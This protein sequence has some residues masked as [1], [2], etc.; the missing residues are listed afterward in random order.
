MSGAVE[1]QAF[2]FGAGNGLSG[3]R[4]QRFEVLNWGTFHREV[5]RIAPGGENSLLTGDIGSG[6][7]TLVD[8]LTTLLVPHQKITYNKAAGAEGRE[9]SL[10][11]YVRGE[12]KS[13]QDEATQGARAVALRDENSYSVLL[14]WFHNAG[15]DQGASLAQVFW[16]KEGQRRPERFFVIAESPLTIRGDFSDFGGDVQ[17]LRKRLRKQK[18]VAVFD[19]FKEYAARFRRL[20][21]IQQEKALE[22]F[23]QAVSMKSVGNLTD[24]V[25]THML[26]GFEVGSRIEELRRNFENLN[27]AHEA[28]LKAKD[29]IERL[30]PL[31]VE[32]GKHERYQQE[33]G[34]LSAC[35]EA[36]EPWFAEQRVGLTRERMARLEGELRTALRRK[37]RLQGEADAL[38]LKADTLKAG[39]EDSGGSRLRAIDQDIL[40]LEPQRR[41]RQAALEKYS[42]YCTSLELDIARDV[43]GFERNRLQADE[44]LTRMADET[45]RLDQQKTRL[46]VMLHGLREQGRDLESELASLNGRESNIPRHMLRIRQRMAETLEEEVLP[47]AG[48]LL[49]M[50]DRE[51]RWAGAAERLLHGFGLSLLVPETHYAEVSRYVDKTDLKGRLVYYRTHRRATPKGGAEPHPDAL[52]RKLMIKPES[53][54]YD[55]LKGWLDS[56]FDHVCCDRLEDFHRQPKAVTRQGQ[57]K[58]GGRRHEKDD[59]YDL[60]DRSRYVLGWSNREKIAALERKLEEVAGGIADQGHEIQRIADAIG[61][62]TR[63][64]ANANYLLNVERFESIDWETPGR[65]ITRLQQEKREIEESSDRLQSLRSQLRIV[66][67]AVQA[68]REKISESIAEYARIEERLSTLGTERKEAERLCAVWDGTERQRLQQLRDESDT[69]TTNLQNLEKQQRQLRLYIQALIDKIEARRKRCNERVIKWMQIYKDR[70]QPETQEVDAAIGSLQEF[71]AM[72]NALEAE[73]L[74]R[75][76]ARFRRLLRDETING[77]QLFQAQLDRE[78]QEIGDKIDA[79]NNSLR[80]IE[81]NAGSYIILL[82]DPALDAEIRDFRQQLRQLLSGA[83]DEEQLYT[84]EKFLQVKAI[85]DRFN[86]REGVSDLDRRWTRK[87]TDVRNWFNFSASERWREDDAEREFYSD[88]AGKSGG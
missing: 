53:P 32:G 44:L 19:T 4:L 49:Q 51:Q 41:E 60:Y 38:E 73:D 3:F 15:F 16:H 56:R 7:S 36:L 75:H 28:V 42:G 70:Y 33:I 26:E 83:L 13:E 62:L 8:A 34:T 6:K 24:F 85:I 14:A 67:G 57:I 46:A 25:R 84:E 39:I 74:P 52:C 63:L 5:W 81:Y 69:E 79:I 1:N 68:K 9:R 64:R 29:Q 10:A 40:R 21:G 47:F 22:L 37:E 20:F 82:R 31:V 59:R 12:Y 87:V 50:D 80:E 11:S 23:Y 2:D 45:E 86:G 17:T 65:E 76:E 78:Q 30:R 43:D 72:L 48:E 88:A 61:K 58:S 55:W 18:S 66:T 27:R 71:G 77:V 35:R 54:L